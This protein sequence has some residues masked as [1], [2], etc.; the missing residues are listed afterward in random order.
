MGQGHSHAHHAAPPAAPAPSGGPASSAPG[1]HVSAELLAAKELAALHGPQRAIAEIIPTKHHASG[2][3]SVSE[4]RE[5]ELAPPAP[6]TSG[7]P[8]PAPAT[9][10]AWVV[11]RP[12]KVDDDSTVVLEQAWPVTAPGK[13]EVRVKVACAALNPVD[14][15]RP[16][17]FN[18]ESLKTMAFPA[19]MGCDGSG[20]IESVGPGTDT[21]L[22]PGDRV[23]FHNNIMSP[24]GTFAEYT[25]C[26]ADAITLV[27][28]SVSFADAAAAPCAGYTAFFALFDKL[29]LQ[30]GQT[31]LVLGGAGGVGSYAI[32]LAKLCGCR[33]VATCSAASAQFVKGTLGADATIDYR[34]LSPA[35]QLQA[36]LAAAGGEVDAVFD[37]VGVLADRNMLALACTAVR[38]GGHLA[39][40]MPS[41]PSGHETRFFT[42]QLSL[43]F[44]FTGGC[45]SSD[46]SRP[47]L[48]A[49]GASVMQLMDTGAGGRRLASHVTE[50]IQ[51]SQ[52]RQGLITLR[53]NGGRGKIVTSFL[54]PAIARRA[55]L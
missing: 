41:P 48:A 19:V 18:E 23:V 46:K 10:K 6:S 34:E 38:F 7:V 13:G 49:V 5:T 55:A 22:R 36:I 51:F 3:E 11:R 42:K 16:T 54:P 24:H 37:T 2:P 14:F 32:A 27:P 15:K 50:I 47:A 39:T 26:A 52:V 17:G 44:V 31:L 8:A 21:T 53:D 25:I 4:R 43:H 9:M 12:G 40:T 28:P 1:P 45:Y 30:P 20:T 35:E 29:R 33:V